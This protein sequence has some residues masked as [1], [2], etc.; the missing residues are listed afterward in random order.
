MEERDAYS[1]RKDSERAYSLKK[2][3][4]DLLYP[5]IF[6]SYPS[7]EVLLIDSSPSYLDS[8]EP[9]Y[10]LKGGEKNDKNGRA[11]GRRS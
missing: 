1:E 5:E 8:V 2:N 3:F 11:N 7:L 6:P 4:E 10:R 9:Y